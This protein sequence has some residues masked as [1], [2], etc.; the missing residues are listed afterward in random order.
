MVK[1]AAPLHQDWAYGEAMASLGAKVLRAEVKDTDGRTAA[2]AQITARSFGLLRWAVCT[3]GPVWTKPLT[4]VEK[5][6]MIRQVREHS[7][8]ARPRVLAFTLPE[9][10]TSTTP[11]RARLTKIVTGLNTASIDLTPALDTLRARLRGK[12][13]NR[14]RAAEKASIT[15]KQRP[16]KAKHLDWLTA[17]EQ[18][19]QADRGYAGLPPAFTTAFLNSAGRKGV[20]LWN[21]EIGGQTVAAMMFLR[22]GDAAT[23]HVGWTSPEA[24]RVSAHNLLLWRAMSEL[25]V[26]GVNR[27]DLGPIDTEHATGLARFKLGAGANVTTLAGTFI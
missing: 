22:H 4:D 3:C 8:L 19:Q 27:L 2:M 11:S 6:N 26:S 9:P 20:C 13:R 17:T 24:R 5:A 16:A 15:V 25:K 12:W 10:S 21:A 7:P 14:L 23:Y 1:A 18:R